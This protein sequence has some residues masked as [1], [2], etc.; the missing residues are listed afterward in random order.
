MDVDVAGI[1]AYL[2]VPKLMRSV[3]SSI[4]CPHL[5]LS[6]LVSRVVILARVKHRFIKVT[7]VEI[8]NGPDLLTM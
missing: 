3:R 7:I 5:D 1:D 4:D 2:D 6:K 8:E